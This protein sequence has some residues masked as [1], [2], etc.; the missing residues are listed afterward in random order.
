MIKSIKKEIIN[1][2]EIKK[3]RFICHLKP[4]NNVQEAKEYILT[5]KKQ[6]FT[7]TH[8]CTVYI[9]DNKIKFD[10]D[11][12]P[13]GTAG[14][15]MSQVLQRNNLTNIVCVVTRYFGGIKLGGGGLIRAYTKSVSLALQNVELTLLI[16]GLEIEVVVDYTQNDTFLYMLKKNNYKIVK[17]EY[18]LKII[19]LLQIERKELEKFKNNVSKINHLIEFNITKEIKIIKNK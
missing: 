18:S 1:E 7:A 17:Q 10:D 11:G 19:Y 4:I 14:L 3:S 13:S 6:H 12:E 15:P 8:N 5:I 9:V 2:Y 16:D